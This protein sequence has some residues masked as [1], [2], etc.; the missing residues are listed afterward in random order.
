MAEDVV[1]T[2]VAPG[3]F[4]GPRKGVKEALLCKKVKTIIN[5]QSTWSNQETIDCF[6][7]LC[8]RIVIA[9]CPFLPPTKQVV[10]STLAILI[11]CEEKYYPVYIHCR[12]GCDRTGFIIAK[13]R[14]KV[15]GWSRDAAVS[16][17]IAEGN[18]WW[19]RWWTWFI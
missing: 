18:S 8:N 10:E 13:Y 16:E 1:I 11:I 15:D 17:M 12:K 19:L 2:E 9:M 3:V 7:Y 5:L 14:M 6:Y 4:R